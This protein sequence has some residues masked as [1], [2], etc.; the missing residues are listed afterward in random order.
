MVRHIVLHLDE[1]FFNKIK[2][3]KIKREKFGKISWE[4]YIKV[5]FGF[6]K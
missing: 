6:R 3:D 4:D 2:A 1:E 5:L